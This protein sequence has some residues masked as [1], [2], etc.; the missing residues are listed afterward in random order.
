MTFTN[1]ILQLVLNYDTNQEKVFIKSE[2]RNESNRSVNAFRAVKNQ[3][4][5]EFFENQQN[6]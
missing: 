2:F 4:R 1:E 3:L 6:Q 5:M